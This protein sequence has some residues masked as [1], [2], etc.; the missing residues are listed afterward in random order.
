[1][2]LTVEETQK[3]RKII[4]DV[5]LEV[6]SEEAL[7]YMKMVPHKGFLKSLKSHWR[8]DG[9]GQATMQSICWLFCW[10]TM[11]NNPKNEKT[12]ESC[13]EIFNMIFDHSYEWFDREVTYELARKLRYDKSD[14][15]N[16]DREFAL[17]NK[18]LKQKS[19][20]KVG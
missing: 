6:C 5:R 15:S 1:M 12:A 8:V 10:A 13:N 20:S 11:G 17:I 19:P 14:S 16:E 7:R 18:Y 2:P 3:A 4:S 9:D